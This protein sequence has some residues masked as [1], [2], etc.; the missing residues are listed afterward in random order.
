MTSPPIPAP[1][2]SAAVVTER[3]SLATSDVR[4]AVA[5]DPNAHKPVPDGC[6][7]VPTDEVFRLLAADKRDIMPQLDDPCVTWWCGNHNR[8][9][10]WGWCSHGWKTRDYLAPPKVWAVKTTEVRE[11]PHG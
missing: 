3:R 7:V 1:K 4:I 8:I 6:A 5:S 11:V 10:V 2:P 9:L